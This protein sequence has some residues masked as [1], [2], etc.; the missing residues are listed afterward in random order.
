MGDLY[1]T[2]IRLQEEGYRWLELKVN[3]IELELPGHLEVGPRDSSLLVVMV[4]GHKSY[5]ITLTFRP[6]REAKQ[7]QSQHMPHIISSSI[8]KV[9]EQV[10]LE[11]S[12]PKKKWSRN[13][14]NPDVPCLTLER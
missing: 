9:K 1:R 8:L 3:Q 14:Q 6:L 11:S 12:S 13:L 5:H 7:D 2:G 4:P 10:W